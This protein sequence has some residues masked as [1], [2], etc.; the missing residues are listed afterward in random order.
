MTAS[1]GE[2]EAIAL[3]GDRLGD[4][5]GVAGIGDDG[6]LLDAT[7]GRVIACD[8]MVEGVHWRPE[9]S[10][11][12]DVGW[13]LVAS[14]VSDIYAMGAAPTACVLAMT[15]G[16]T[17][18]D[19]GGFVDGFTAA[20]DRM[21]PGLALV[22]GD[23][24]RGPASVLS[25]T[26]VGRAAGPAVTR[27]GARPG[28]TLWCDGPLGHA[29]AGLA[30][31]GRGEPDAEPSLVAAHRRPT[32]DVPDV[33]RWAGADATAAIDV[34]DGLGLDAWRLARASGV[35]LELRAPLP[36]RDGLK[37]VAARLGVDP[38]DWQLAGGDD[39]VRIV[40]AA[41]R[42]G[43]GFADIGA[44]LDGPPALTLVCPDGTSRTLDPTGY[45]HDPKR[46]DPLASGEAK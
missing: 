38:M 6:A 8:T 34:S 19:V 2:L 16:P 13:K 28:Q 26:V 20:R 7:D 12:F 18:F 40:A 39:Y 11:S 21:A 22:G 4:R 15:M 30:L 32:F 3:L 31:L 35:G 9:W 24:T 14:N 23:T 45:R 1:L 10:T 5:S 25:L 17:G 29:A 41:R 44:V 46:S 33:S 36:G 37:A 43:P 42:P 27:A